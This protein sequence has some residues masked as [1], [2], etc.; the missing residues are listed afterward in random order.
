MQ[1]SQ[2]KRL[3][4]LVRECS[5]IWIATQEQTFTRGFGARFLIAL[6]RGDS[7]IHSY[8]SKTHWI[9][10]DRFNLLYNHLHPRLKF[11]NRRS[12]REHTLIRHMLTS[13]TISGPGWCVTHSASSDFSL[14][15]S[16]RKCLRSWVRRTEV[17]AMCALS[18]LVGSSY[19]QCDV[20]ARL[21]TIS[22]RCLSVTSEHAI[23]RCLCI[24][25]FRPKLLSRSCSCSEANVHSVAD[26]PENPNLSLFYGICVSY[27]YGRCD[28]G[29]PTS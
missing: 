6:P 2:P 11:G 4:L 12:F 15:R 23:C 28:G 20:Q 1:L 24:E 3:H 16:L 8:L 26:D 25:V 9:K 13:D 27:S 17:V 10:I 14:R 19:S 29:F 5:S 18:H 22:I 21:S 7:A